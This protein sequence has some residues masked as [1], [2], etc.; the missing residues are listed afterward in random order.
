MKP[1]WAG[2]YIFNDKRLT[3]IHYLI[4]IDES[5]APFGKQILIILIAMLV[6]FL[7][8]CSNIAYQPSKK[9]F[10]EP[11]KFGLNYDD[12]YF[13][14]RDGTSLHGWFFPAPEDK[15][16]KGIVIQFHGNAE[17]ITTHF[18]SL[19][20]ITKNTYSLFIGGIVIQWS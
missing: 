7:P 10:Y 12:V 5:P 16:E 19:A 17:N 13:K 6:L 1:K 18:L 15:E 3:F 11:K 14:S 20:W 8:A 2:T 9:F 4:A